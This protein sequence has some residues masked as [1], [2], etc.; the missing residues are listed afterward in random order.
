MAEA[1]SV[2]LKGQENF[3]ELFR[4]LDERGMQEEKGQITALVDYM[5]SMEEQLGRVLKELQ[6]VKQQVVKTGQRGQQQEGQQQE[7]QRQESQQQGS[8]QQWGQQQGGQQRGR[9]QQNVQRALKILE[10]KIKAAKA[11][12]ADYKNQLMDGVNRAID[13]C[14]DGGT[15]ALYKTIDFLGIQK[16][17]AG[18]KRHLNQAIEAADRGI[19]SLGSIGDEMHGVKAHM[20]NIKR[21]LAGKAPLAE[22][23]RDVEKGA[24]FQIQKI[25]YGTMRSLERMEK[26]TDYAAGRLSGL[27]EKSKEIQKSSVIKKLKTI[28]AQK[29]MEGGGRV[30]RRT[31][32]AAR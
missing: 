26:Y 13:G 19:D 6:A 7:G 21:V 11:E 5:D 4:L 15:L 22:G 12:L 3:K 30:H 10:A 8:Q 16:G 28:Q 31:K 20:G 17:L 18:V 32:E 9:Q 27:E 14:R 25:L 29:Q 2:P 23:S 24:V 1:L